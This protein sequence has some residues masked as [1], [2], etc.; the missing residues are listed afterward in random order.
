MH[1]GCDSIICPDNYIDNWTLD[2]NKELISSVW[3]LKDKAAG[4]HCMK[5]VE[6]WKYLGDILSSNAKCDANIKERVRRGT[7][8]AIQVT[9]ML[10]DLCLG[11][12][13]FQ[14]ANTLRSSLFL[15]SLI[16]NAESWVNVSNKH[17]SDL[18][19][20]DE[21]L[22]RGILAAQR[23]TPKEALF[24]ETGNIPVKYV[25]ISRRV[26]FLHYILCQDEDS[27]ISRFFAAQCADPIK[28]DWA[29]TVK[30]DLEF[31]NI[32]LS[33][34]EISSY[35]KK[36]FKLIV[37][38]AVK[39]KAF[40]DLVKA[41]QGHSKG[42]EITYRDLSLQE[43]LKANSPLTNKEKRFLF[44]ARTRGLDVKNNFKQGKKDLQCRLCRKHIEDQQ[45]L[46]TCEALDQGSYA[47][48]ST[49]PRYSDIFS[50]NLEKL[51]AITRVLHKKF[52]NFT[53]HVN[54]QA[55]HSL[56]ALLQMLFS[57][58]ITL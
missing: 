33:F 34:E 43:Y 14:A 46:L 17:M 19:A 9:Q 26:N 35:S 22:L 11:K 50:E 57:L 47:H 56:L 31:L 55:P 44:S 36:A 53:Y 5:K 52:D 7:G 23:N 24:L 48:F 39:A 38:D 18:E 13:Y 29:S 58:L 54:R 12:F 15:S 45:S 6:E 2:S 30:K 20:T 25:I 21:Q 10:D 4:L 27:L 37:K 41:Q 49:Q 32:D 51:A 1:V 16:S 8:A 40:S 42:K 3:E 28:G